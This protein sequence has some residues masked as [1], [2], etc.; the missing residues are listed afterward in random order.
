MTQLRSVTC[1]MG[2]HSVTCYP[3][4]VNTT[5]LNLSY[6]G[7]YFTYLRG[8]EGWV[9]LVDLI[10]PSWVVQWL[11]VGLVIEGRWL[12]SRLGSR[13]SDLLITS[14]TL[15][16]CTTQEYF[17]NG[18]AAHKRPLSALDALSKSKYEKK[19]RKQIK[20]S[21]KLTAIRHRHRNANRQT[22]RKTCTVCLKHSVNISA[23]FTASDSRE[24]TCTTAVELR[25]R[26]KICDLIVLSSGRWVKQAD[27]IT[28]QL[29]VNGSLYLAHLTPV[30]SFFVLLYVF[31]WL[32]CTTG[33]FV[34]W[35][36]TCGALLWWLL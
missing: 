6:T 12:D 1:H 24:R 33:H 17:L 23:L 13:T 10:A 21:G 27:F 26:K 32:Y 28:K 35:C 20:I 19:I 25:P 8:T 34:Y 29:Q 18:T 30:P 11:S 4:H 9:D 22:D 36:T 7:R 5:H 3:T 14:P 15:N 16:H 31:N 2:S